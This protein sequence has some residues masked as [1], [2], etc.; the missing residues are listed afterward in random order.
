MSSKKSNKVATLLKRY[1]WLVETIQQAGKIT[2]EEIN[3]KWTN[4]D[5]LN[6]LKEDIPLR[7]FHNHRIAIE[8][9][10][11]IN[12]ECDRQNGYRYYIE[13]DEDENKDKNSKNGALT[14]MLNAF[15]ISNLLNESKGI[16]DRILFENIPSGHQYLTKFIGA[17][18]ENLTVEMT[19]QSFGRKEPNT[20][21]IEPYCLK[22]FR[23]RWYVLAR[24]P[25]Y[26]QLRI[27]SLDR[28]Q[29]LK[30]TNSRFDYPADFSPEGFFYYSFGIIA[31]S[32]QDLETVEVKVYNNQRKYFETL[33]LHHSQT[34][35]EENSE[36]AMFQYTICPTYDFV[37]E[38]FMHAEN[39][40]VIKPE[41]L[42]KEFANKVQQ[43]SK[44][45][46]RKI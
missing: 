13:K 38:L 32:N 30:I 43:M 23:Q 10:F 35:I 26:D 22:V 36:Y 46:N 21:E 27:Y 14:W 3:I 17:I 5:D 24:S 16:R 42:R 2:Y 18:K 6:E 33:P 4:S 12:I 15:A 40:E 45:Y 31:S 44:M 7:T 41:W 11:N 9:L 34:L 37:Q 20:Y 8:E 19:Y 28:I 39:V 29:E 1:I 25:Y